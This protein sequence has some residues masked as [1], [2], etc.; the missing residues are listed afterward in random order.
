MESDIRDYKGGGSRDAGGQEK[1]E[2]VGKRR[3]CPTRRNKNIGFDG[4]V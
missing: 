3:Q 4:Y 1:E 2:W